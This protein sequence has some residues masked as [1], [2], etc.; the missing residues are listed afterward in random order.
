MLVGVRR[1]ARGGHVIRRACRSA[2]FMPHAAFTREGKQPDAAKCSS[3]KPA[4]GATLKILGL[5]AW[6]VRQR[7]E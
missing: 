7:H 3:G 1:T 4:N 5:K 2:A 6:P